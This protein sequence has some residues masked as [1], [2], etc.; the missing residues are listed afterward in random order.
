M[1]VGIRWVFFD[2]GSTLLDESGAIHRRVR[3]TTEGSDV[4]YQLFRDAMLEAFCKNR[5]GYRE[6]LERFGLQKMPWHSEEERIYPG[7]KD[8]LERLRGQY[9]LGVIANQVPGVEERLRDFGISEYF[10]LVLASA[11]VGLSK[12][13]PRMFQLALDRAGCR[14]EQAAMVGD[15][16][17]NDIL[18]ARALGM[19]TVWVRQGDWKY[20]LPRSPEETPD[21]IVED[22]KELDVILKQL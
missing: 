16:L 22:L 5:D 21:F 14:A 1:I 10:E 19:K 7:M 15:R 4:T 17:D 12:P 20:A 18:P 13:D 9:S 6:A 2:L 11:E 8:L 3:E